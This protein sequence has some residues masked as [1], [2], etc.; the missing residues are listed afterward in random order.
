[1]GNR[2]KHTTLL[3]ELLALVVW[4]TI[5]AV[6]LRTAWLMARRG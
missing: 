1:M 6:V 3:L 5:I 4:G 2:D